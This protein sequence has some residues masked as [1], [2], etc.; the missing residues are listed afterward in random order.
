MRNGSILLWM[1]SVLRAFVSSC[2]HLN[3]I[4]CIRALTAFSEHPLRLESIVDTEVNLC[5]T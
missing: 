3:T 2:L 5:Q 1:A 4:V